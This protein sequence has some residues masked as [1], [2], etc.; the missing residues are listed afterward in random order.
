MFM[1]RNMLERST[2]VKRQFRYT[3]GRPSPERPKVR[4]DELRLVLLPAR[5]GTELADS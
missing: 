1:G 3:K 4:N 5:G 2:V